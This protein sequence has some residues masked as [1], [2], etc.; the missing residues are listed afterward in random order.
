MYQIG[1]FDRFLIDTL[2]GN[3]KNLAI[4]GGVAKIMYHPY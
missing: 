3:S 2:E 1:K 4:P